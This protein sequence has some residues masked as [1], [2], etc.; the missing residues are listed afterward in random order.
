MI[1]EI[2]MKKK[3]DQGF[4]LLELI[5]A[6]TIF[7][8]AAAV[9]L[10]S[11]SSWLATY[12]LKA[13]ARNLASTFQKARSEALI[14]RAS[15]AVTFNTAVDG[16]TYDYIV[17]LDTGTVNWKY[18]VGERLL[19]AAN[20]SEDSGI[21]F[22]TGGISFTSNAVGKPSVAFNT[23]GWPRFKD[24]S[25]GG[26]SVAIKNSRGSTQTVVLSPLGGVQIN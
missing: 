8:V 10:P 11:F 25:L 26:G 9:A 13:S 19:L 15:C 2:L 5:V 17:Y 12:H 14:N 16:T 18:D 20:L 3:Q 7:M 6:V 4:T 23:R 21:T 22:T 24:G 1:K